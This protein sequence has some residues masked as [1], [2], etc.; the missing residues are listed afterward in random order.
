MNHY[1]HHIGDFVKDTMGF[2]QGAIGA[3]RLLMDAYYANEEAPAAEDVYVIGRATTPTERRNVERALQKFD[4]RDG[5]YYHKR[6]E[7]ELAAYRARADS[8]RENGKKGGRKPT[9]EPTE[10]PRQTEADTETLSHGVTQSEPSGKLASSHKP[11]ENNLSEKERYGDG[12]IPA[13]EPPPRAFPPGE[14]PKANDERVEA[15]HGIAIASRVR[16]SILDAQQW[17]AEGLTEAQLLTAISRAKAKKPPG[18]VISL[19]WLQCFVREVRES[20]AGYDRDA[21]IAETI[22]AINA[23]EAASAT[24]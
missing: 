21:V 10:N 23:K 7:E 24:H 5:R 13:P 3:Y 2:N 4:L 19:G 15:L 6:V 14:F 12:D 16:A 9:M 8:A 20:G 1:P 18:E 22:A 17:V 11:V